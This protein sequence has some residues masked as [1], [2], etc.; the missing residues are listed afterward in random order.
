MATVNFKRL[1]AKQAAEILERLQEELGEPAF[2]R[3]A[4][5]RPVAGDENLSGKDFPVALDGKTIGW[6]RGGD[7]AEVYADLLSFL[8]R[9]EAEKKDAQRDRMDQED[10]IARLREFALRFTE[11]PDLGDICLAIVDEVTGSIQATGASVMLVDEDTGN[12]EVVAG[13][14]KKFDAADRPT[15]KPGVGIAGDVVLSGKAEIINDAKNDPRYVKGAREIASLICVPI[16]ARGRCIGAVNVSS[17][18]PVR[19]EEADVKL[20]A[21]L[22]AQ[23]AGALENARMY[24]KL[25]KE[26]GGSGSAALS[27]PL[28]LRLLR[29]AEG[30]TPAPGDAGVDK[31]AV[32][33]FN[34]RSFGE[35]YQA[36]SPQQAVAFLESLFETV[37]PPVRQRGGW[38]A[39]WGTDSFVALF[40]D[41]VGGA[42]AAVAAAV[43][44]RKKAAALAHQR[45]AAGFLEMDTETAV[46]TG[47]AGVGVVAAGGGARAVPMGEPVWVAARLAR[48]CRLYGAGILISDQ[49]RKELSASPPSMRELDIVRY[50]A[51][52]P[53][54]TLYEVF[55][56]EPESVRKEKEHT[57]KHLE[58]AVRL[59]RHKSFAEAVRAFEDLKRYMPFDRTLDLFRKRCLNFVKTPPPTDW[60]GVTRLPDF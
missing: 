58:E 23:A 50:G 38:V 1:V 25:R 3:D 9:S 40:D 32:L 34:L 20:V 54:Y 24:E 46:H 28:L 22:A 2:F 27:H 53:N 29:K 10:Q 43:D 60:V 52:E 47:M 21:D 30:E 7:K 5:D 35:H 14:G 31:V 26:S 49:A 17:E 15:L 48:L 13:F 36:L 55:S 11:N 12:L 19:Y 8:A 33:A 4:S 56:G 59:Y 45:R 6:V 41:E 18:R 57:R 39:A 16:M 37:T 51:R 44:M 42:D